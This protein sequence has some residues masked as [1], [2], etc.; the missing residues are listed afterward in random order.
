MVTITNKIPQNILYYDV[1]VEKASLYTVGV[2]Q[3]RM[4]KIKNSSQY[5][6]CGVSNERG[7]VLWCLQKTLTR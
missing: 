7:H 1:E 6:H 2:L 3:K 4:M 5:S